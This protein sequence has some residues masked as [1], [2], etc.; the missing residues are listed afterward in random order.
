M[1]DL[2]GLIAEARNSFK[3]TNASANLTHRLADALEA[4]RGKVRQQ[5]AKL[6]AVRDILNRDDF[7]DD[8][9]HDE[10][11]YRQAAERKLADI[12][13]ALG[14]VMLA[15]PDA[16]ARVRELHRESETYRETCVECSVGENLIDWPCRTIRAL[17]GAPEPEEKP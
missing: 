3:A 9:E 12:E 8:W 11:V 13:E 16:I 15:V 2:D 5:R 6:V 10:W 1:T 17:D 4:E 14:S 7:G